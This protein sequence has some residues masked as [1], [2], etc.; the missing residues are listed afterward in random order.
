MAEEKAK[1]KSIIL[2]AEIHTKFKKFCM[3]KSLKL[4]GVIENL[5]ELFIKDYKNVQ[6]QIDNLKD[7]K[8][9]ESEDKAVE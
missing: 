7:E 5:M 4:G 9:P 2:D 3:G 8:V 6:K 1:Q